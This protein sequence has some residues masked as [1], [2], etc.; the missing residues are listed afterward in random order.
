MASSMDKIFEGHH[1]RLAALQ[2]N[3]SSNKF[4]NGIAWV[5]GTLAPL[6]EAQ[7]PMLDQ[8]FLHSDL[9]YDV[10]SIWD[11]RFFRLEDHLTRLDQSC[12]KL[13]LRIPLARKAIKKTLLDMARRSG[14]QDAYVMLIVTRGLSRVP[15][16]GS[17]A[18]VEDLENRLYMF[19]Q[20]FVWVMEPEVQR[21]GGKA[22]IARTVRRISPG[23]VDPTIKNLQ[24]GDL[25]K[26]LMEAADRSATYPF[27]TDGDGNLTEGS[28]YNIVLIKGRVLYTP[29][30]GV[31][32]GWTRRSVLEVAKA[33]GL[34]TRVEV[35]PVELAYHCD[36]IFMC[37][38]AGGVMPITILDGQKVG[39]GNIGPITR[40]IWDGY[41]QMHYDP[42]HSFKID[43]AADFGADN[44]IKRLERL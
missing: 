3:A 30:R 40:V 41:W 11:G 33:N 22:I 34:E 4:A 39:T 27:L 15:R 28:G 16:G 10:P 6:H 38:T 8:G 32:E 20:P 2:A 29:D 7:I 17:G 21:I 36:E 26:G 43:Y 25:T 18:R 24:W 13:R 31:L 44:D 42:H 1:S 37:T 23:A 12:K 9:T 19:I 35:V 5:D 14:I